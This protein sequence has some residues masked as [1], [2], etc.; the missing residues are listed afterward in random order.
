MTAPGGPSGKCQAESDTG[1][2]YGNLTLTG[3]IRHTSENDMLIGNEESLHPLCHAESD[4]LS[5]R[6]LIVINGADKSGECGNI[7]V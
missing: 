3:G 4:Q 1:P 2:A 6:K 7:P 5:F